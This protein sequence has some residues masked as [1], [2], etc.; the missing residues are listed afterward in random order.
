MELSD[1]KLR[2]NN[3]KAILEKYHVKSIGIFGSFARGEQKSRSDIDILVDFYNDDNMDLF[4]FI[5]LKNYLSDRL[6]RKVDLVMR[7]SLKPYIA[8]HVLEEVVYL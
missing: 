2:L 6:G 4:T 1:I 3:E 5:E 7:D 8:K